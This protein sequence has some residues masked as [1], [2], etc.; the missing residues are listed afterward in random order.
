MTPCTCD[1]CKARELGVSPI[2]Y[3]FRNNPVALKYVKRHPGFPGYKYEKA[4]NEEKEHG[5]EWD[6]LFK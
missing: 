1:L 4:A 6:I 3:A 2:E 5:G